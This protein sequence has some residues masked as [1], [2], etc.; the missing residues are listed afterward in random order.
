MSDE[1]GFAI[2]PKKRPVRAPPPSNK[3]KQQ[4]TRNG[5]LGKQPSTSSASTQRQLG[6]GEADDGRPVGC[7]GS[8]D[9]HDDADSDDFAEDPDREAQ[10][11][12]TPPKLPAPLDRLKRL[13]VRVST[14][15]AFVALQRQVTCT[16]DLLRSAVSNGDAD[17]EAASSRAGKGPLL[18]G[19][20]RAASGQVATDLRI[21]DLGCMRALVPDM[22]DL[23]WVDRDALA[24]ASLGEMG[25]G[26]KA[27]GG[28]PVLVVEFVDAAPMRPSPQKRTRTSNGHLIGTKAVSLVKEATRPSSSIPGL[29]RK[30]Q[31]RGRKFDAAL[32]RFHLGAT[33]AGEN[34]FLKLRVL[35]L[36]FVPVEPETS[37]GT[38]HALTCEAEEVLAASAGHHD[39]LKALLDNI[40]NEEL[41]SG[42]IPE[43]GWKVNECRQPAYAELSE[44]LS[45]G[46][47]EALLRSNGIEQ[48]YT[49]QAKALDSISKGQHVALA[50]DQLRSLRSIL[51][52]CSHLSDFV[53]HTYDGD[54][55]LHGQ[56]RAKI[57]SEAS[58]IFTNP[59]MLHA[60][61][62]PNHNTW[63]EFLA[64]LR[65]VIV[66]E[67]HYYY[68]RFGGHCAMVMRRLRRICA[69]YH[70][71]EVQF[72]SCSATIANPAKH[73]K[74]FFGVDEVTV[75]DVDGSPCGQKH[76]IVWNPPMRDT[77]DPK[78]GR[79]SFLEE[80]VR[81]MC[82]L[83]VREL[84]E[85]LRLSPK[86]ALAELIMSYRG[87]YS[88]EER[89]DI[90]RRMF[91]GQLLG[92]VATNALELGVDIGS[93]DAVVH[94]G[95]PF[96]IASYR[97]Q[98]G[99]AGRREKESVSIMI[100]NGEN[101]LDQYYVENPNLLFDGPVDSIYLDI[102]NE[103]ILECHLQCTAAEIGILPEDLEIWFGKCNSGEALET[104][105]D[106]SAMIVNTRT[107]V[108]EL[109]R[110]YLLW[111][112]V[113]GVFFASRKYEGNP[114]RVFQIRGVDD[115]DSFRIVDM[116][117]GKDIEDV[118]AR[119]APFTVY[120]GAIFIHQGHSYFV[121]EVNYERRYA[122]VRPTRVD[123]I[124]AVRDYTNL[125]PL[126][127]L[128]T[129]PLEAPDADGIQ[130]SPN[131][132]YSGNLRMSTV[133]FGYFKINPGTRQILEAC[134]G[135]EAP[136]ITR[137][138][139][140]FWVDVPQPAVAHIEACGRSSESG[141]HAA[142]HIL[143]SLLPK[144][145]T[146]PTSGQT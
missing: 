88:P 124:T 84:R 102:T 95:F 128:E 8:G 37:A 81:S 78:Q 96:N 80:G 92:I 118:E 18:S 97:Q 104:K 134:A 41:Y 43:G 66:D 74:T 146:I 75:I 53:V 45:E 111:D 114:A 120:E 101:P 7:R 33:A 132:A 110:K 83:L 113:H 34:S 122:K 1:G 99:R 130:A 73:M 6:S 107:P 94:L 55:P 116:L 40:F 5:P 70:N 117:T 25:R 59:D 57:R 140:G 67:L 142:G 77:K 125:D 11:R 44:P 89:R 139:R 22:I 26:A 72:I 98:L 135:M 106:T 121:A 2:N 27:G 115:D 39:H 103:L 76:Q 105:A 58:V 32:E 63:K 69:Q 49:H 35:A 71:H 20:S 23:Y 90:E 19:S 9:D 62:L 143:L 13:F 38:S 144:V 141:I 30:L 112:D 91:G 108:L 109:G 3:L 16:F 131:F 36:D 24:E 82:E 68:G 123:Y 127:V 54:V 126:E 42:Q 93:L 52:H 129:Q 61:V 133:C 28:D 136:P 60:S 15:Y 87:G 48:F 47:V 119:R 56:E 17:C 79:Q 65:Y 31:A 10:Q 100:A 4:R 64:N 85:N 29:A 12:R 14:V 21:E 137:E 50:Q 51:S 46:L 145:V 86:P 138:V